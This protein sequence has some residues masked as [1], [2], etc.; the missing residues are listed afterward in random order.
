MLFESEYGIEWRV[1]WLCDD[2]FECLPH[3]DAKLF[4]LRFAEAIPV[5]ADLS[6]VYDQW[7]AWML[8]D[9]THGLIKISDEPSVKAMA[10][11]FARASRGDEPS[12]PEWES[13]STAAMAARDAM[14][15][16][17]ERD[18]RDVWAAMAARTARDERGAR[19]ARAAMAALAARVARDTR[20]ARDA[21]A[22]LAAR[23]ARATW[24][25]AAADK[26][27]ELLGMAQ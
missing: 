15:A 8:G 3:Q 12:N 19:A 22:A 20:A 11:L 7:C 10:D 21:R 18:A 9:P 26:F 1:A 4:P 5:G 27:I 14:A 23:V 6:H 25:R 16:M 17:A 2:L 13:V 24:S